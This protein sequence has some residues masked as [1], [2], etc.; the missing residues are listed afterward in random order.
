MQSEKDNA[1]AQSFAAGEQKG[2]EYIFNRLYA[3]LV[4]FARK[5]CADM[6]EPEETAKDVVVDAF[7]KT[8]KSREKFCEY[9]VIRGYLYS[10]VK[11]G[12]FQ[13]L[14]RNRRI[15]RTIIDREYS[16]FNEQVK[17]GFYEKMFLALNRL[18]EKRRKIIEMRYLEEKDTHQISLELGIDLSTVRNQISNALW[19]LREMFGITKEDVLA[20]YERLVKRIVSSHPT[21]DARKGRL[22][23]YT[24]HHI[25]GLRNKWNGSAGGL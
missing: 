16:P 6:P 17:S 8:W 4:G 24:K 2:F 11:N 9:L 23:G 5:L 14:E 7:T 12:C 3:P 13:E 15:K 22:Y 25:R 18:P 1:A 10:C 19:S 20:R 21:I